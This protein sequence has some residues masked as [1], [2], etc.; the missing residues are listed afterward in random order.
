MG[1][2]HPVDH[3]PDLAAAT[4]VLEYIVCAQP[5][6]LIALLDRIDQLEQALAE[7][8]SRSPAANLDS[9]YPDW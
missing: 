4:G 2:S 7:T 6:T 5:S 3:H 9:S 1:T 8:A